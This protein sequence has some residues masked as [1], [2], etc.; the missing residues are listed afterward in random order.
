MAPMT[1]LVIDNPQAAGH[2]FYGVR[3]LLL[4]PH[5]ADHIPGWQDLSLQFFFANLERYLK[6]LPLENVVAKHAGY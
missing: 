5:T 6:G 2:A 3:N 1:V 4:S